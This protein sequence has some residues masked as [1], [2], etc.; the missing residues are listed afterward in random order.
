MMR[1]AARA[2]RLHLLPGALALAFFAF[3]NLRSPIVNED[4]VLYLL[5]AFVCTLLP[6]P[7][8]GIDGAA[9]AAMDLPGS[10]VWIDD[11]HRPLAMGAFYFG[12]LAWIELRPW[13]SSPGNRRAERP[14][15]PR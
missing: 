11:P 3:A 7:R 13:G 5:L 10:G 8:L 15:G 6:L 1:R 4:G 12:L 9:R 14:G 2:A